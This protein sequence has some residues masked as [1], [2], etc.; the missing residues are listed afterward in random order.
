[1]QQPVRRVRW[2]GKGLHVHPE[3]VEELENDGRWWKVR[4]TAVNPRDTL[5]LD[6]CDVWQP[7]QGRMTFTT[8]VALDTQV[9]F[10]RQ[11]W[12]EGKRL[13][14]GTVRARM[15]VRL[16]LRCE[17]T[18]RLETKDFLP[19]AV[20]RLRVVGSELAYDNFVVEHIAGVGG[21][22]AKLLGEAAHASLKQWRPSLER[23]LLERANAA[24][25]KAADTREVRLGLAALLGPKGGGLPL[26]PVGK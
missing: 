15:R 10:D 1:L 4:V 17:A 12:H 24:I 20:V 22:M 11:R 25:A 19:E 7:E 23:N 6:L 8:Y 5:V 26:V 21:E 3:A 14:S 13:Y 18:G 16:N 2:R 9:E